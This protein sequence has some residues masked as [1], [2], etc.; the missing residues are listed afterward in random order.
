MAF[1]WHINKFAESNIC[2]TSKSIDFDSDSAA[3][4]EHLGATLP[5]GRK[6]FDM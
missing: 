4:R 3:R 5:I 1:K 2:F 6:L